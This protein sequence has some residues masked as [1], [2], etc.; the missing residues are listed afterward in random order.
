MKPHWLLVAAVGVLALAAVWL[1]VEA[2]SQAPLVL[3]VLALVGLALAAGVADF[4]QRRPGTRVVAL[5]ATL[6]AVAGAV[7]VPVAALPGVQPTTFIV[8]AAGHALG[9]AVGF[10]VGV[11]AAVTSNTVLGHGLWTPFQALAWGLAGIAAATV[12]RR[13]GVKALAAVGLAWGLVFG[14]LT[15]VVVWLTTQPVLT[16]QTYLAVAATSL[17]FDLLHGATTAALFVAAGD[18]ILTTLRRA[19][20][21]LTV[22]FEDP[23]SEAEQ[24][25]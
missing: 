9:P 1:P 4:E 14:A 19:R 18:P 22:R 25:S 2:G 23:P 6:G 7:R 24:A 21:R 17:P 11:L 5:V 12:P 16:W 3:V 8:M 13:W 20:E 15:N 10:V